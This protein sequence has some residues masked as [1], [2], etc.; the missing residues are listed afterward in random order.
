MTLK[1]RKTNPV[2]LGPSGLIFLH[3]FKDP[4]MEILELHY[5]LQFLS[6]K[7]SSFKRTKNIDLEKI[8]FLKKISHFSLFQ[9]KEVNFIF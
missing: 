9:R 4:F 6:K 8:L 7:V 3:A 5:F 1:I 2:I